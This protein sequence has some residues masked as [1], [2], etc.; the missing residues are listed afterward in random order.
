ME[1]QQIQTLYDQALESFVEKA[2]KDPNIIAVI[3]YGSAA[4]RDAWQGSDIDI[5]VVAKDN[6]LKGES[7]SIDE[8]GIIINIDA[9]SRT[10]LKRWLEKDGGG[11][12]GHSLM[13]KAKIIYTTDDD[14]YDYIE[15]NKQLGEYD[16]E[17]NMFFLAGWVLSGMHK[18]RKWV[19][20]KNDLTYARLYILKTVESIARMEMLAHKKIP[21]REAIIEVT[22]LNPELMERFYKK[23]INGELTKEEI[24]QLIDE[25]HEYVD[26]YLDT[27]LSVALECIGYNKPCSVTYISKYFGAWSHDIT[28]IF[29]YLWKKGHIE[30]QTQTI[31][32]MPKGKLLYE[33]IVYVCFSEELRVKSE[34]LKNLKG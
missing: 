24:Y 29:E 3:V 16:I 5:F 34:E 12:F 18:V 10:A 33:E 6:K 26:R 9:G 30:K 23:P 19:E 1:Q 31:R 17:K 8:N 20:V 11:S 4:F 27:V 13:Y 7:Y 15:E 2:K 22:P 25:A 21:T 28:E 14:L 32:I